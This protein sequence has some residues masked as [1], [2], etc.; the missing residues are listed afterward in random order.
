MEQP[1]V[2]RRVGERDSKFYILD[3]DNNILHMPTRIHL[4][5]RQPDGTWLPHPVSTS[6]F[7]AERKDVDMV[8][9]RPL[10]GDWKKAFAEFQDTA[11]ASENRFLGDTATA[12]DRVLANPGAAAPS[13]KAFRRT[14]VEGR[15]FAIVTAR[16]HSA[17]T[18]KKGVRLFIDRV[19]SPGERAEMMASLRGY[20]ACFDGVEAFGDDPAELDHY[21]DLNHYHAVT[22][23]AFEALVAAAHNGAPLGQEERKLLAIRT[24]IEHIIRILEEKSALGK[25]VSVGFSDDDPG[26]VN[27]VVNYIDELKRLFPSVKFVVYDTSSPTLEGGRKITVSGQMD[28][29]L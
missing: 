18:L 4:E 11:D 1:R 7:S 14:L 25:P 5:K 16:G 19:L 17:E 2:N 26:N 13:F 10:D 12:I 3:W 27:A 6:V 22:S 8:S 24:F 9:Y 15:L 20:R 23:P 29:G 21:L 28:L